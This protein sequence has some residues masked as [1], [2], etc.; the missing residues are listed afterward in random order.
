MEN[1]EKRQETIISE[2]IK[3]E[4]ARDFFEKIKNKMIEI[5]REKREESLPKE[6]TEFL[7][8]RKYLSERGISEFGLFGEKVI[9][10]GMH[11]EKVVDKGVK[12]EESYLTTSGDENP[13]IQEYERK[14]QEVDQLDKEIADLEKELK[15]I[16]DNVLLVFFSKKHFEKI[17]ITKNKITDKK[18]L[19]ESKIPS[20]SE[21]KLYKLLMTMSDEEKLAILENLKTARQTHDAYFKSNFDQIDYDEKKYSREYMDEKTEKSFEEVFNEALMKVLED[22][23]INIQEIYEKIGQTTDLATDKESTKEEKDIFLS[24]I[25]EYFINESYKNQQEK[26]EMTDKETLRKQLIE[27][28]KRKLEEIKGLQK[29]LENNKEE[30]NIE[31]QKED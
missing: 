14:K 31:E 16:E 26:N 17:D 3:D 29:E 2:L 10:D 7:K 9:G 18:K 20:E 1:K 11:F 13:Y 12:I 30:K 6:Y 24:N 4:K 21:E 22:E 8:A 23:N 27:R 25:V 28:I 15:K 5:A 19:R